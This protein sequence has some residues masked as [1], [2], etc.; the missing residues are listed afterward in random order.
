MLLLRVF[1]G[2]LSKS[3]GA[4]VVLE[5]GHIDWDLVTYTNF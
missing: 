1:L 3:M 5:W 2:G 4:N